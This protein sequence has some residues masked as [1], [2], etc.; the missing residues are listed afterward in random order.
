MIGCG[1]VELRARQWRVR[2]AFR[3][4]SPATFWLICWSLGG[5]LVISVIPSKRV[6]RIFPVVPPLCLLIAVQADAFLKQKNVTR[7]LRWLGSALAV[8]IIFSASY[9]AVRVVAGF[10]D[11][12]NALSTFGRKVRDE[13]APRNWRYEA[14][15]STDEGLPLY[16]TR[17]HFL[18]PDHAIADWNAG[19]ID[20]LAVPANEAPQLMREL[21]DATIRFESVTR[22]NLRRPNYVLLTH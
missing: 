12:R 20:A 18:K 5:L 19:K 15:G 13:A 10:R 9:V 4:I 6:D 21:H 2:E 7:K 22:K 3:K 11:H 14:I 17:P 1:I 16:L 8:A